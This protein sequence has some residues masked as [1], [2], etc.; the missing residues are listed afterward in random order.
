MR[1]LAIAL[2]VAALLGGCG[3]PAATESD[4][5]GWLSA[6]A[7]CLNLY[8]EANSIYPQHWSQLYPEGG[9]AFGPATFKTGTADLK[10][11]ELDGY[12][13]TYVP[14]VQEF[15]LTA[16]PKPG[17]TGRRSF[18]IDQTRAVRHCV[19]TAEHATAGPDDRTL[20]AQPAPCQAP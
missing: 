5:G 4:A 19:A 9:P 16:T 13:Y 3:K 2:V 14:G 17:T 7:L 11:F 18:W 12:L 8:N 10:D 6:L 1:K 20:A 15:T